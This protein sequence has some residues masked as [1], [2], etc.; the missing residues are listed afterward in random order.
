MS[1]SKVF[2]LPDMQ[3]GSNQLDPNLL[4]ALNQNGGFGGNGNWMWIFFLFFLWP[5]MRGNGYGFGGDSSGFGPLSS[6]LNND[7]GREL[8]MQAINR[9]G[10]AI[11]GLAQMFN[12]KSD[13]ITQ[14]ING[15]MT[16]VQNVGNQVGMSGMQI[17]NAVQAGNT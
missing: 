15:V 13:T 10:G 17:I 14:A 4:M 7:A 11:D 5:L 16:Q 8:L 1:D 9:N 3:A 6:Q 12:C 2:M